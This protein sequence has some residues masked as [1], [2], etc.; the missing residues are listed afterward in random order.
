MNIA[1][2]N[3]DEFIQKYIEKEVKNRPFYGDGFYENWIKEQ[4]FEY[5]N[6]RKEG[7]VFSTNFS[8]VYGEQQIVIPFEALIPYLRDGDIFEEIVN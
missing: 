4:K 2:F 6:I 8:G 7:L 5:F 3:Y 1:R